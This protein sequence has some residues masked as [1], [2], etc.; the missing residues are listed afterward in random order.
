MRVRTVKCFDGYCMNMHFDKEE[1]VERRF[2]FFLMILENST[3]CL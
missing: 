1:T 2:V 3:Q